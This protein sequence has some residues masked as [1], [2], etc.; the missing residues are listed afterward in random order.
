MYLAHVNFGKAETPP[1]GE[2]P[3][4]GFDDLVESYLYSLQRNGQICGDFVFSTHRGERIAYLYLARPDSFGLEHH[5]EYGRADLE[6][7]KPFFPAAPKWQLMDDSV[8]DAFPALATS[9]HVYLFATAF[10]GCSPVRC[11]DTGEPLPLYQLPIPFDSREH[12]LFWSR[13]Y[14]RMDG[15]WFSSGELEIPAYRQMAEPGSLLA[16]QGRKVLRKLEQ[17]SGV[18]AYYFLMRYAGRN[19]EAEPQ[20]RCPGC[21]GEWFVRT[22]ASG[23]P[24]HQ[25]EFR[26]EPCRLVSH[27]ADS[28]EDEDLEMAQIGEWK[29]E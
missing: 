9:S 8:P 17:A 21:G 4:Y 15:I 12:L 6:N 3:E 18:P 26:C 7:M 13:E 16:K 2:P 10:S 22:R 24:F 11:G 1:G 19:K 5:S 20:R 28:Y 14:S 23:E 29:E 25:F 27:T